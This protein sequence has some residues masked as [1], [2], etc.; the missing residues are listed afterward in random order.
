MSILVCT[1]PEFSGRL[2]RR[3]LKTT[4]VAADFRGTVIDPLTGSLGWRIQPYAGHERGGIGACRIRPRCPAPRPGKRSSAELVGHASY[5]YCPSHARWFWGLRLYLLCTPEG[6][7]VVW[8]LAKANLGEREV[9]QSLL[10]HDRPLI[11]DGQVIVADKGFAGKDF[12]DFTAGLGAIL[13]RP[14][15][16][17]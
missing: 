14:N 12:E 11:E 13:L 5:G 3:L 8:G 7:P 16:K 15:R 6:T 17:D 1:T 2:C 9:A 10:E 4:N